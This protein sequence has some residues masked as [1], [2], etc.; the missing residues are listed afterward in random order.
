MGTI[1]PVF[2]D[3]VGEYK[4]EN[5]RQLIEAGFLALK[6]G[7]TLV[8]STC[9]MEPEENEGTVSYLLNKYPEAKVQKM[10]NEQQ[11]GD[12]EIRWMKQF[13]KIVKTLHYAD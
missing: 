3:P 7:G 2:P 12:S 10:Q 11:S 13:R 5:Q 8:Y 6:P 9:T 4:V 1:T